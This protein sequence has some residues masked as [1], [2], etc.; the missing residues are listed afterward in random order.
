LHSLAVLG[1]PLAL[2]FFTLIY[3]F[4]FKRSAIAARQKAYW[5]GINVPCSLV[6]VISF[7][8]LAFS[9]YQNEQKQRYDMARWKANVAGELVQWTVGTSHARW[10]QDYPAP[11]K[12]EVRLLAKGPPPALCDALEKTH[13][14]YAAQD[15]L[16][17]YRAALSAL[18]SL[19]QSLMAKYE[20]TG[21]VTA[22]R[23]AELMNTQAMEIPLSRWNGS[24]PGYT[25]IILLLSCLLALSAAVRVVTVYV[26]WKIQLLEDAERGLGSTN[27]ADTARPE[28][29]SS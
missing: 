17:A 24:T 19:P 10:C 22:L 18:E 13:A 5:K 15:R 20:V 8:L 12:T 23:R 1:L 3:F 11:Q 27:S 25:W 2:F 21:M 7:L 28:D 6:A 26:E 29:L 16:P 14:S 9:G 4:V